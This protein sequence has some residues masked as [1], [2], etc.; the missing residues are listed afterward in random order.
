MVDRN[1]SLLIFIVDRTTSRCA[2]NVLYLLISL[3]FLSY[4][5]TEHAFIGLSLGPIHTYTH[6]LIYI[7]IY[8]YKYYTNNVYTVLHTRT[9]VVV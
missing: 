7:H 6:A 2:D 8:L 5:A 1:P 3:S 9:F 4:A